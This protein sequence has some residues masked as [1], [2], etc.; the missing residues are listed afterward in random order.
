MNLRVLVPAVG[1]GL[2][3][4]LVVWASVNWFSVTDYK[5]TSGLEKGGGHYFNFGEVFF[6]VLNRSFDSVFKAGRLQKPR[7]FENTQSSGARQNLERVQSNPNYLG[8]AQEGL[9]GGP[10]VRTLIRLY[11]SPLHVVIPRESNFHTLTDLKNRRVYLGAQG[12]GP[13]VISELVIKHYGLTLSELASEGEA[14]WNFAE[15]AKALMAG[16]IDAAFFMGGVGMEAVKALARDGRFTLLEVDRAEG[17]T[18]VLPYL[19]K[20]RIPH[21]T[22]S[23]PMAFPDRDITTIEAEEIFICHSDLDDRTA[24]LMVEAIFRNSPQLIAALPNLSSFLK[25]DQLHGRMFYPVHPGAVAFYENSAIP[26]RI[27]WRPLWNSFK[28]NWEVVLT[29]LGVLSLIK[30]II[31]YVCRYNTRRRVKTQLAAT[32]KALGRIEAQ[33]SEPTFHDTQ[34]ARQEI[35]DIQSNLAKLLAHGEIKIEEHDALSTY[36]RSCAR[37]LGRNT[38][39]SGRTNQPIDLPAKKFGLGRQ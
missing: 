18:K 30:P 27:E 35:M 29:V 25:S 9:P 15:A 38:R 4:L 24:Y 21:G 39:A 32:L 1:I 22:Y 23:S 28:G 34:A 17:I 20:S 31:T 3:L 33:L 11:G 37:K 5:I 2:V 36:A 19:A 6:D 10:N 8:F 7:S 13:R 14:K 16:R 12:T 26:S